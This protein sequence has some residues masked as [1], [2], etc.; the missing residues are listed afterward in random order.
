MSNS[1]SSP[2]STDSCS[3]S[4]I[5]RKSCCSASSALMRRLGSSSRQRL[6]KSSDS[7]SSSLRPSP[8]S[9]R[10]VLQR[11]MRSSEKPATPMV[12]MVVSNMQPC[13]WAA[14]RMRFW[15]KMV[16]ISIMASTSSAELKKGKRRDRMVSRMTPADQM[17]I[18]VVCSVHLKSTSGARKPRVPARLARREGR[19]SFFG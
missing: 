2:S 4:P 16:A 13:S 17:S 3:S 19:V 9:L 6:R 8:V 5:F 10:Q 15:P 11:M 14:A 18:L 1:S 12:G 7:F